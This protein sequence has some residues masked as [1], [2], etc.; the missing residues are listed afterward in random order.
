MHEVH[1]HHVENRKVNLPILHIK[2]RLEP[3]FFAD[4]PVIPGPSFES[5]PMERSAFKTESKPA[6]QYASGLSRSFA[7]PGIGYNFQTCA[8]PFSDPH[9]S[10]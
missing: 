4:S 1:P 10:S 8:R 3:L 6:R 7:V 9:F 2:K 5:A